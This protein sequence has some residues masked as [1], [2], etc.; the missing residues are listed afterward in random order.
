[1]YNV[2]LV[3]DERIILEGIASVVDW[4]ALGTRLVGKVLDGKQAWDLI[5]EQQPHIVI[6]DIKMPEMDGLELIEKTREKYPEIVFIILSG[7]EHFSLAQS[8]MKLGVRHYLLKPC[9]E[10]KIMQV[11]EEVVEELKEMERRGAFILNNKANFAKVLPKLKEQFLKEAITNKTYGERE[12]QYYGRLLGI[13]IAGKPVR[14]MLFEIEGEYDFEHLFALQNIAS[15]LVG[16]AGRHIYLNTTIRDRLVLLA[17]EWTMDEWT[18]LMMKVREVYREY[19]RL[20]ITITISKPGMIQHIRRMYREALECLSHR[21]YLG[22][23]SI[24]TG[25]D[26]DMDGSR[27]EEIPFDGDLL[28]AV[29]R[30][31]DLERVRQVIHDIFAGLKA[32]KPS[33]VVIQYYV[34][35][36]FLVIARLN[37]KRELEDHVRQLLLSGGLTTIDHAKR[38]LLEMAEEAANEFLEA[39][40]QS[41]SRTVERVKQYVQEHLADESLTLSKLAQEVFHLNVDYLGKLFRKETGEKFSNYL[42]RVRMEEA[43]KLIARSDGLK[44]VEIAAKVGFGSNPPYFSQVFKRHTGYTPSE[45]KRTSV[46]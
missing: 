20:D 19:Y 28:S 42:M 3:D 43:K 18:A 13:D 16:K 14:L 35:E 22:E 2:L 27:E 30:S 26:I 38:Y 36:I 33:I 45:Y 24:I 4:E 8:A 29:I 15:E 23:G 34:L 21:I 1:M 31:G 41:Q 6:T 46:F 9:N 37:R 10:H 12:W 40:R 11:L 17:E 44:V 25:D 39:N 32:A 7:H 5:Q